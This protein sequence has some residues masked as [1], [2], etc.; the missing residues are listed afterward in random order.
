MVS[1]RERERRNKKGH[2][3]TVRKE[4]TSNRRLGGLR[5]AT[6]PRGWGTTRRRRTQTRRAAVLT[7][8]NISL[9]ADGGERNIGGEEEGEADDDEDADND[10]SHIG[11]ES[12]L[13]LFVGNWGA[14]AGSRGTIR[15]S[16]LFVAGSRGAIGG[17]GGSVGSSGGAIGGSRGAVAGSWGRVSA[18]RGSRGGSSV[19]VIVA[20]GSVTLG[21][22][23]LQLGGLS[24]GGA[25]ERNSADSCF[26]EHC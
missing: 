15:G 10:E 1:S 6:R 25:H 3:A 8:G 14:V 17:S 18:S 13:L 7:F 20:V 19:G 2:H 5:E 23:L 26:S 22:F 16:G 11:E 24:Q 9:P 21:D 12:G 4:K